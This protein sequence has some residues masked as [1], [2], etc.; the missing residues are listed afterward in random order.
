MQPLTAPSPPPSEPWRITW[1]SVPTGRAPRIL[2][3]A[4]GWALLVPLLLLI[5]FLIVRP[6]GLLK[7][8]EAR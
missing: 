8:R 6:T 5:V 4:I 1:R 3:G 7:A 2:L